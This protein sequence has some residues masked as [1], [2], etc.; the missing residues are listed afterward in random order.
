VWDRFTEPVG[1]YETSCI[2]TACLPDT[3]ALPHSTKM[4]V[5][6]LSTEGIRSS[7]TAHVI[8]IWFLSRQQD[9]GRILGTVDV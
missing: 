4:I 9:A 5:Q 3:T 6:E 2:S 7:V 8:N 1:S